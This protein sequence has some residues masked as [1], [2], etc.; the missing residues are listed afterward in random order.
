M[1]DAAFE[2]GWWGLEPGELGLQSRLQIHAVQGQG[3][4]K[5]VELLAVS[6]GRASGSAGAVCSWCGC[7]RRGVLVSLVAVSAWD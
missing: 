5:I 4:Q 3:S 7:R 6:W 1:T 2:E